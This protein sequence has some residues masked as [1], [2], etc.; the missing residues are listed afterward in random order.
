[1]TLGGRVCSASGWRS[2][3]G[4]WTDLDAYTEARW[5][6]GRG[7]FKTTKV[8]GFLTYPGSQ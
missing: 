2:V 3:R 7:R 5:R 6:S 1:M 4:A 8:D